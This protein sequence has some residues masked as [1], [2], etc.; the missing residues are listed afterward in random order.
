MILLKNIEE[1]LA[2][3]NWRSSLLTLSPESEVVWADTCISWLAL[4]TILCFVFSLLFDF[5]SSFVDTTLLIVLFILFTCF[6]CLC[7][8]FMLYLTDYHLQVVV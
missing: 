2:V 8:Q 4:L 7:S 3:F 1:D 5:G 6:V